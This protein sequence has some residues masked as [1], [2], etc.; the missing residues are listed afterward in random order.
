MCR[1]N[2]PNVYES[3]KVVKNRNPSIDLSTGTICFQ[4]LSFIF[5]RVNR[6]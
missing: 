3:Q 1:S 6:H 5:L 2:E 4:Q